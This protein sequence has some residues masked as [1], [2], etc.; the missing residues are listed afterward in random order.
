MRRLALFAVLV[1]LPFAQARAPSPPTPSSAADCAPFADLIAPEAAPRAMTVRAAAGRLHFAKNGSAQFGCPSVAVMCL[2][3]RTVAPGD[4][5]VAVAAYGGYVC[6]IFTTPP[7]SATVSSGWLPGT[8]LAFANPAGP[9]DWAGDWRSWPERAIAISSAPKGRIRLHGVATFGAGDPARVER[10]AVNTGEFD[11]TAAASGSSSL[12]FLVGG[13]DAALPFDASS[14]RTTALCGLHLWRRGPYLVAA[15][16]LQC[17]GN[18]VTFTGVYRRS[19]K[20][21]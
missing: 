6:A 14:A 8:A 18:G 12:A 3:A 10:G 9:P 1:A 17:G 2:D 5:V 15:D 21:S 20:P 4:Q 13:G 16:N 11:V 7:P 19:G